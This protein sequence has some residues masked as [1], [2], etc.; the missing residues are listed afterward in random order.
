[1]GK[2]WKK[3]ADIL[4]RT[5]TNIRDKWREL[6]GDNYLERR[7]DEWSL[8]EI[9]NLLKLVE[10]SYGHKFLKENVEQKLLQI[11]KENA[12]SIIKKTKNGET[13]FYLN[14]EKKHEILK[15]LLDAVKKV[16]A[17]I[18]SD[19]LNWTAISHKMKT[20]SVDDCRN[21]WTKQVYL[22]LTSK[23]RFT[24]KHEQNLA[25]MYFYYIFKAE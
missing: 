20:R 17:K 4:G 5:P 23:P 10:T 7:K 3:I 21:K 11:I 25:N 18:P 2:E 6:G 16:N 19:N 9:I 12:E 1:M 13:Q 8:E 24:P 15:D 14:G 22:F